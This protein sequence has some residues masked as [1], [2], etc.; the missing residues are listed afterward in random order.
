[1]NKVDKSVQ[2]L[3]KKLKTCTRNSTMIQRFENPENLEIKSWASQTNDAMG[4]CNG[5]M[6]WDDAMDV[7]DARESIPSWPDHS[8]EYTKGKVE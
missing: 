7:S 1:M 5:M 8:A 3:N 6:Q 2:N 4:W